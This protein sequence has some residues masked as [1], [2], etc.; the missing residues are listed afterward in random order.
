MVQAGPDTLPAT[1]AASNGTYA[2]GVAYEGVNGHTAQ[3][4]LYHPDGPNAADEPEAKFQL[5]AVR[6]AQDPASRTDT[7][8]SS[9][10]SSFWTSL[11]LGMSAAGPLGPVVVAAAEVTVAVAEAVVVVE[12]T[13]PQVEDTVKQAIEVEKAN[14]PAQLCPSARAHRDGSV[15]SCCSRPAGI[16]ARQVTGN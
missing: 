16:C 13:S 10:Q 4:D 11:M 12:E 14:A 1:E 6:Y 15:M 8:A 7:E 9:K 2:D 5:A 3:N